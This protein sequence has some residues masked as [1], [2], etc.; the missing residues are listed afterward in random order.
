MLVSNY[1]CANRIPKLDFKL[2]RRSSNHRS[3][4][5]VGGL[6]LPKVLKNTTNM[7]SKYNILSQEPSALR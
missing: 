6:C 1:K 4:K 7:L 3:N 5:H 2:K